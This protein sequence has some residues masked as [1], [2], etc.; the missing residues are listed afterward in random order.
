MTDAANRCGKTARTGIAT[1]CSYRS[2]VSPGGRGRRSDVVATATAGFALVGRLGRVI[3]RLV[4]QQYRRADRFAFGRGDKARP[5]QM[6][7]DGE[8]VPDSPELDL[9]LRFA[10]HEQVEV[11]GTDDRFANRLTTEPYKGEGGISG[12]SGWNLEFE[13]GRR[14]RGGVSG[15]SVPSIGRCYA[16]D[17]QEKR[18]ERAMVMARGAA[19]HGSDAF[20][21]AD[22]LLLER[23]PRNWV[24]SANLMSVRDALALLG[25]F[26][27]VRE[28]FVVDLGDG[29]R[30]HYDRAM[31]YWV[32][33]RDLTPAG[34]R[35]FSACVTSDTHTGDDALTSVGASVFERIERSFRARDR[36]HEQLQLPPSQDAATEAVFYFDVA[37]FMLGGAFD[38]VA[39][40]AHVAHGLGSV[41]DR[42]GWSKKWLKKLAN[43]NEPLAQMIAWGRPHRD[44]REMIAV[45]RNAIHQEILRTSTW[46]SRGERS[47]RV[48]VPRSIER[49]LEEIVGRA[50][51]LEE[52]GLSRQIDR[53]LYIDPG[54]YLEAI[55]PRAFAA[56]NAFMEATTVENLPGVDAANL[57]KGPPT[58]DDTFTGEIADRIRLLGGVG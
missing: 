22:P 45:L 44:S 1:E 56:L 13:G 6:F 2:P 36:M 46:V 48:I 14:S 51:T 50:G 34:W 28:D 4:H 58:D 53:R 43:A 30:F 31:F 23:V 18:G 54:I 47:E 41:D 38:G 37:L 3:P 25:L 15:T 12:F 49:S 9:L 57:S 40:I 19:N 32:L 5:L 11:V 33:V 42:V 26:L 21:T 17:G 27:R 29:Y 20:V 10:R 55:L 39:K 16:D 24:E 7:V 8:T 35:W 52:F